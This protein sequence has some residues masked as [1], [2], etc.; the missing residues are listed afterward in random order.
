PGEPPQYTIQSHPV[1]WR[2]LIAVTESLGRDR[3]FGAHEDGYVFELDRGNRF[4][5][6]PIKA[7]LVLV[8]DSQGAPY[9][10]KRYSDGLIFGSTSG[11]AQ[12]TLCSSGD[13]TQPDPA[14][15]FP[16]FFGNANGPATA[17]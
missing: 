10:K 6:Q 11:F 3:I 16:Q 1:A 2:T 7:F 13:N 4:D 15:S 8:A 5:D 12:F 17:D 9:A 14:N